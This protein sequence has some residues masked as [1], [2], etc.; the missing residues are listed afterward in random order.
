MIDTATFQWPDFTAAATFF[1]ARRRGSNADSDAAVSRPRTRSTTSYS[2]TTARLSNSRIRRQTALE[3]V[4]FAIS[5]RTN[6]HL[7]GV[8][9]NR[10]A[11]SIVLR[12]YS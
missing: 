8:F 12:T 5:I 6:G 7:C 2:S 11:G 1:A 9:I 10:Y 3:I 4:R